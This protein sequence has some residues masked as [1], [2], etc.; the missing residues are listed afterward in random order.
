MTSDS[1]IKRIKEQ[2]LAKT[3]KRECYT[4]SDMIDGK[5]EA[6]TLKKWNAH[7][8]LEVYSRKNTALA[9]PIAG[10]IDLSSLVL[11]AIRPSATGRMLVNMHETT[12]DK[13]KIRRRTKGKAV[14]TARGN[15]SVYSYAGRSDFLEI[16]PDLELGVEDAWSRNDL[17]DAEWNIETEAVM[18]LRADLMERETQVIIEKLNSLNADQYGGHLAVNVSNGFTAENLIELWSAADQ[19]DYSPDICVIS[20]PTLAHLLK[21][22]DFKDSTLLGSFVNYSTGMVGNFLG[23]QMIVSSLHPTD[24]VF[25]LNKQRALQYVLRRDS[26]LTPFEKPPHDWML[27][28]SMRYGL[29]F[30]DK[31]AVFVA[32]T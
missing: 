22:A 6:D 8:L 30:G 1:E 16:K 24:R 19:K 27:N 32:R 31:K 23:M 15:G 29:E 2:L 3:A 14:K 11:D 28:I 13:V 10:L 7:P 12:H 5:I 26:L 20:K 25:A 21:D 17:E 18:D 9:D 4:M